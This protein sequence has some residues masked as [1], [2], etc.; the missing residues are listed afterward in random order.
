[1]PPGP[2]HSSA[3]KAGCLRSL[4][5]EAASGEAFLGCQGVGRAMA[6]PPKF[7]GWND[8]HPL[9][10]CV[11]CLEEGLTR[12]GSPEPMTAPPQHLVLGRKGQGPA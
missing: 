11:K 3:V 6:S 5:A 12:P 7:R 1:M 9:N 8:L 2:N 4:W 10:Q